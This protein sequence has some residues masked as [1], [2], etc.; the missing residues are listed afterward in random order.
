MPIAVEAVSK[1]AFKKWV[2]TAKKKFA[3]AGTAAPVARV[4]RAGGR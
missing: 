2:E 3:R 4:A 1:E